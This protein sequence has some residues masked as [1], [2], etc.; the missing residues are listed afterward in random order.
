MPRGVH[1]RTGPAPDPNALRRKSA[2]NG[3]DWLAL[4]RAGRKG[5][6]PAWPFTE[7]SPRERAIWN[8]IW[9]LPQALAWESL[10]LHDQVALYCRRLAIAEQ[11]DASAA[12]ATLARQLQDSLGLSAPGLRSMRWKIEDAPVEEKPEANVTS[13]R[14]RLTVVNSDKAS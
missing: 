13:A 7:A 3:D 8:R 1:G 9:K 6:A 5:K 12:E 2:T 10:L 14:S 11:P 4:P